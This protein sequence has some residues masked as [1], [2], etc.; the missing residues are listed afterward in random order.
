MSG[1]PPRADDVYK[2]L[3][4][5]LSQCTQCDYIPIGVAPGSTLP[6]GIC[7]SIQVPVAICE[8]TLVNRATIPSIYNVEMSEADVEYSQ[9]M[10]ANTKKFLMHTEDGTE[11]RIAFETGHVAGLSPPFFTVPV[12]TSY[13]ED[14]I[15]PPELS[16]FFAGICSGL[17]MEIIAWA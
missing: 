7:A 8:S 2:C 11:F 9:V 3:Y 10:P 4:D 13:N 17:T 12:N 5:I 14:L 16:L 6:V 15:E 1:W